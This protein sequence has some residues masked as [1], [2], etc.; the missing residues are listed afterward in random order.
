M[1]RARALLTPPAPGMPASLGTLL[2]ATAMVVLTASFSVTGLAFSDPADQGQVAP[3]SDID[4]RVGRNDKSGRIEIYGATGSRASVRREGDQVVI[5]LPGKSQPDIGDIRA[6]PPIGIGGVDV[7]SD[8]RATEVWLKV[9]DGYDTHFGRGDGGVYIQID[10]SAVAQAPTGAIDGHVTVNLQNAP[11]APVRDVHGPAPGEHVNVASAAPTVP[12]EVEDTDGGRDL[13]FSFSGP[14][15]AAVFRRG[16]AVWVVFDNEAVLKLPDTIKDGNVIQDVQWTHNDGFTAMR[17]T[18]PTA[19]S[20]S[21]Q[22]DGLVWRVRLG[23]RPLDNNAAQVNV[24]RDDSTGVPGLNAN[25]A[26]ATKIAWIRDPAV[27]DRM[28]VIPARAPVK[29][30][31]T[32]RTTLEAT[33]ASTAQGV[34]VTHMTPDVKVAVDGDLIEVSRPQGLTLSAIDPNARP[35]DSR[36]EYKSALYPALMNPDWSAVPPEGFLARYNDLQAAAADEASAGLGAPTKARLSLARFLIG[37]GLSFEAQGAL[38]LL[39]KQSPRALDDPQVRGLR[40]VAKMLSGRYADATGDLSAAQ[41]VADPASRLWAGYAETKAGHYADAV[42]DFKAGMKAAGEFPVAWRTRLGAA[43]AYAAMQTNDLAT[44]QT[45]IGFATSQPAEPLDRLAAFLIDAQIIEASGDHL[46]ALG[47]YSAVSRASDD[48]IAAPAMMHAA[49]LSYQLRKADA[50]K[51]LATLASLRYRWRGDDTELQLVA[52]MGQIYLSE[53][54]YRD[55]LE[56]LRSGNQTFADK[57]QAIQIQASL[58]TAFRNL[59]LGGMADGLQPIEALGLFND[60]KE[61]TPIGADGDEMVRKIVRRLVDVDLLDQAAEL[62]DYQINHRLDGV[63]KSSVASDLAAIYLMDRNPQKALETLWNTRTTLLPK[64]V[65]SERRVLE[66]RALDDLNEPDKALD[67]LGP[68]TSPDADDVRADIFW[69]Q[70]DW[71]KAASVLEKRLG[72]RYKTDTALSLSE[73]SQVI[74][75]GVA[76]SLA[77]DQP[78]LTRL[79]DH[80]GKFAD[81]ASSSDAMRVALAPLDAGPISAKS[82]ALAAASTDSFA[83]WVAGMKKRFREKDDAAAAAIK[84]LP[85]SNALPSAVQP[86]AVPAKKA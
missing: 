82:F 25:L 40:V 66:A 41:L 77:K 6:N 57:P 23:G 55:A 27:G 33:F 11:A 15:A 18:A 37:Q 17:I 12:V 22:N 44:A 8:P 58:N 64:D 19:G 60:F 14:A 68:D 78:S 9:S 42:K 26:G 65:M 29:N 69:K 73:E 35:D 30:L 63:A 81:K 72:D 85:A 61:L 62:L 47:V 46:R 2:R 70:Q 7:K 80:F 24:V 49:M 67:A 50:Q 56:V 34:V 53:G 71:P 20:L 76:Y 79:S 3:R 48:R 45:M 28:A 51:T 21:V 74:R 36:L 1:A 86:L 10:P 5:R 54:R 52:N 83:G 32:A 75:A 39:T 31:V 4:I 38:D 43:Y 16:D 13:I 84:T 59:F